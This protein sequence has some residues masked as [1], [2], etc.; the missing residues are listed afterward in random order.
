M[1]TSLRFA[2]NHRVAPQT[3]LDDFFAMAAELGVDAVENR[4]DLP[5]LPIADETDAATVGTAAKRHRLR[6][7]SINALQRFN[8]WS[9]QRA[10]EARD[11][12]D[13]ANACGAEALVMCPVNDTSFRPSESERLEALRRSLGEL[14]PILSERGIIGLVEPLGFEESSLRLK[15]D[16]VDAMAGNRVFRLV[17]DTFHHAIAGEKKLFPAKTGLVHISGVEDPAIPL[18]D[19]RDPHRVLVGPKDRQDKAGQNPSQMSVRN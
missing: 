16:A 13:Y 17:H 18:Y 5:G 11:L 14:A 4:N 7:I 3:P 6:I 2:L 12:A 10:K 1:A 19:M 8:D 15:Q 9:E